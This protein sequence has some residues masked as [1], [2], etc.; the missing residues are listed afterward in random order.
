MHF[1]TY[2]LDIAVDPEKSLFITKSYL[3]FSM[4]QTQG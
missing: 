3:V 1:V 4:F 2:T